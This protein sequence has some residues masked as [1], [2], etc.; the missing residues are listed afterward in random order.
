MHGFG[1]EGWFLDFAGWCVL[2]STPIPHFRG[3]A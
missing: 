1:R 2:T 3:L